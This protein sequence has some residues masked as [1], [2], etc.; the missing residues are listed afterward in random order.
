MDKAS[1]SEKSNVNDTT[2]E[3]FGNIT[4]KLGPQSQYLSQSLKT[5]C[6]SK[7]NNFNQAINTGTRFIDNN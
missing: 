4:M 6:S 3:N 1:H 2:M 7:T 5:G